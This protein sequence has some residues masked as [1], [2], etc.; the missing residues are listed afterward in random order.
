MKL[1]LCLLL[2]GIPLSILTAEEEIHYSATDQDRKTSN[3]EESQLANIVLKSKNLEDLDSK[4][5]LLYSKI[6]N[7]EDVPS[8][9]LK[10]ILKDRS[11]NKQW[12]ALE[13]YSKIEDAGASLELSRS[14][15]NA[16]KEDP[17][18]FYSRY[19]EGDSSALKRMEDALH[20]DYSA[21][22]PATLTNHKLH[23]T[24]FE[25]VLTKLDSLKDNLKGK[26]LKRHNHF[27]EKSYQQ[28]E[29]WKN[30]YKGIIKG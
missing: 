14:C 18:L 29:K 8:Q 5:T 3:Q 21:Y 1:I 11:S 30:R 17:T 25:D 2:L 28:F 15:Y 6:K 26:N 7:P 22:E 16:L 12:G 24:F 20:Y 23:Q 9:L 4:L 10:S 13:H 27:M 19:M